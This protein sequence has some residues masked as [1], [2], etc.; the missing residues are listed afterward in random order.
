MDSGDQ[1]LLYTAMNYHVH[2]LQ[3]AQQQHQET[4]HHL[5]LLAHHLPPRL[6]PP[7]RLR[8]VFLQLLVALL[9]PL[10]PLPRRRP[11]FLRLQV[12]PHLPL[13]P[14][15]LLHRQ[16]RASWPPASAHLLLL[17]LLLLC[18]T[19]FSQKWIWPRFPFLGTSPEFCVRDTCPLKRFAD[20]GF[21]DITSDEDQFRTSVS[22]GRALVLRRNIW[23]PV[24]DFH[25][26]MQP[27]RAV[28]DRHGC[29]CLTPNQS[30]IVQASNPEQ[31]L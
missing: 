17:L 15:Q 7:P 5:S 3:K 16:L 6:P 29:T 21:V 4:M 13:P 8:P 18:S 23:R 12:A 26:A 27:V 10:P 14:P 20:S 22:I 28:V 2:N 11:V 24:E 1:N 30:K 19:C 31:T 9:L 25:R